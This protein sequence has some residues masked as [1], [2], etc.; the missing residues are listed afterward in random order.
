MFRTAV[1]SASAAAALFAGPGCRLFH[2]K[3]EA[4]ACGP[5]AGYRP[6]SVF[7]TARRPGEQTDGYVVPGYPVYPS[8]SPIPSGPPIPSGSPNEL[9]YPTIPPP[10]LPEGS[11]QPTPAT[12]AGNILPPP[13][14]K[15]IGDAKFRN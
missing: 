12:P 4:D 10:G 7:P 1:L 11:A 3:C 8:G 13:A 5:D 15:P 2:K 14:V 6:P 9:P